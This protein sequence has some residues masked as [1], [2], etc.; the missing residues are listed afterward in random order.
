ME[1][2]GYWVPATTEH[3]PRQTLHDSSRYQTQYKHFR[4][5]LKLFPYSL[6]L[7]IACYTNKRLD[8][9]QKAKKKRKIVLTDAHEIMKLIGCFFIMSYNCLP[10]INHYWSKHKSMENSLMKSAFSR[11]RFKLIMSKLYFAEPDKP[12]QASKMYYIKDLISCL[13]L[14]FMKYRQNS[15]FQSIDESM[16]KFKGRCSFK[17]N[18]SL[19]PVKRGIKLWM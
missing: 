11:D 19:K 5:F 14:T 12:E 17:Q 16:T 9:F 3:Q 13:K 2:C 10:S 18:L 1:Q 15:P 7:Q 6:L 4:H 8:I